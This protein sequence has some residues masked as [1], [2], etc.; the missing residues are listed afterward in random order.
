MIPKITFGII[1]LNGESFTRYNLRSLYPF[2]YQIIVVEGVV[3]LGWPNAVMQLAKGLL[4]LVTDALLIHGRQRWTTL[5]RAIS[6]VIS[7]F[8]YTIG[9]RNLW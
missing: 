7:R 9:R 5:V 6:V 2:A 8:G 4:A 1:I 3:G